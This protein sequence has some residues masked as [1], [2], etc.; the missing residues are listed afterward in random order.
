VPLDAE[1]ARLFDVVPIAPT[2]RLERD[3]AELPAI[4][5]LADVDE[6]A[7]GMAADPVS[8]VPHL[9]LVHALVP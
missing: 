1:V 9:E 7:A 5:H 2:H 3:L 8:G 6:G 4:R